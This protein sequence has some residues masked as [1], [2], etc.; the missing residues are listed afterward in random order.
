MDM[1][2]TSG[3]PGVDATKSTKSAPA[4]WGID[5]PYASRNVQE[6]HIIGRI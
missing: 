1:D 6:L 3:V 2:I 5:T 4:S